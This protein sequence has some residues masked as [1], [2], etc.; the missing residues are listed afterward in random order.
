MLQKQQDGNKPMKSTT[1]TQGRKKIMAISNTKNKQETDALTSIAAGAGRASMA[2]TC[3][4]TQQNP[5]EFV[6][7]QQSN[8]EFM[9][10]RCEQTRYELR[11]TRSTRSGE[12]AFA[13]LSA[14]AFAF[15]R[16]AGSLELARGFAS[17]ACTHIRTIR[18]IICTQNV[19]CVVESDNDANWQS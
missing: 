3:A 17:R 1:Q 6:V 8:N 7:C 14:A 11:Q 16:R 18:H 4:C 9:K 10:V 2:T 19:S 5:P 12:C 15:L 13:G